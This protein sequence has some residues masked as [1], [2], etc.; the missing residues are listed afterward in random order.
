MRKIGDNIKLLLDDRKMSQAELARRLGLT[1]GGVNHY[2]KGNRTPSV[3]M[4]KKIARVLGVKVDDI[5]GDDALI[6]MDD[7]E[8]EL[9]ELARNM[10]EEQRK[11]AV[12]LLRMLPKQD[13]KK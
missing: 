8:R 6:T 3:A 10:T 4:L 2:V 1:S 12:E 5:I 9:L 13:Q 7:S 11:A